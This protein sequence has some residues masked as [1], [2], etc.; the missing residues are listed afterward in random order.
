M[1]DGRFNHSVLLTIKVE[2]NVLS[3]KVVNFLN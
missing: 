1:F 2:L 3:K